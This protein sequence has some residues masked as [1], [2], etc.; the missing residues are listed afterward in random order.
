MVI[1]GPFL[2]SFLYALIVYFDIVAEFV[3]KAERKR[4]TLVNKGLFSC[5]F[6]PPKP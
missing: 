3:A 6:P 2:F 4:K 5:Y 1:V